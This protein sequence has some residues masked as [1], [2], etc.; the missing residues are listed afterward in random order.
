MRISITILASIGASLAFATS[1]F[2][3]LSYGNASQAKTDFESLTTEDAF[4]RALTLAGAP[5]GIVRKTSCGGAPDQRQ[6]FPSPLSLRS[7]LEVIRKTDPQYRLQNEKGVTNLIPRGGEPELL[8]VRIK[9]FRAQRVL[10]AN[11]AL[12]KLLALSEVRKRSARLRLNEGLRMEGLSSPPSTSIPRTLHYKNIT[13]RSVLNEIARTY[14]SAVWQYS[15]FHCEGKNQFSI[16][17]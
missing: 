1:Y 4:L 10:T 6:S 8:K 7:T 15:E 2:A 12:E 11:L 9:E 5:G 3:P 17:F 13:L 16:A 14:G